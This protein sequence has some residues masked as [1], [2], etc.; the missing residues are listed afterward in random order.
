MINWIKKKYY[1]YKARKAI[2]RISKQQRKV[3]DRL[4]TLIGACNDKS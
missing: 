1:T 4:K 2:K 3:L